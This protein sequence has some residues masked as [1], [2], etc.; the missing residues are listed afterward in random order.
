[1]RGD[2][3]EA[4]GSIKKCKHSSGSGYRSYKSCTVT[5]TSATATIAFLASYT[6]VQKGNDYISGLGQASHRC[7]LASCSDGKSR[8]IRSKE[9]RAGKAIARGSLTVNVAGGW[10]SKS[11]WVQLEVGKNKARAVNGG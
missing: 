3:L 5:R 4:Q 8:M 11:F 7:R 2:P 6:L 9:S 10:S 1:M